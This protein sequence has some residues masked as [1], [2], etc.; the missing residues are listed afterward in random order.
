ML[1]LHHA[2]PPV[3]M[4]QVQLSIPSVI[5]QT[6]SIQAAADDLD[7]TL[8][9]RNLTLSAARATGTPPPDPQAPTSQHPL[10]A[11]S[12]LQVYVV[13]VT[14]GGVHAG[15]GFVN[16]PPAGSVSMNRASVEV[17]LNRAVPTSSAIGRATAT[18]VVRAHVDFAGVTGQSCPSVLWPVVAT[19]KQLQQQLAQQQQQAQ[20][21]QQAQQQ[22]LQPGTH[23]AS[24][25]PAAADSHHPVM[26]LVPQ[27]GGAGTATTTLPAEEQGNSL[28]ARSEHATE[29]A[30]TPAVAPAVEAAVSIQWELCLQT[31]SSSHVELVAESGQ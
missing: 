21:H 27:Q 17:R 12:E 14:S 1:L 19:L 29:Q 8:E 13:S 15:L 25:M 4:P 2:K 30:A 3:C 9:T 7:V 26:G 31:S 11:S 5:V 22:L 20:Q 28:G 6:S 18:A 24:P 10:A 23:V 16:S